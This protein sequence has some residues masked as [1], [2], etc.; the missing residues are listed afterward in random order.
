MM[1]VTALLAVLGILF[2][3]LFHIIYC[4]TPSWIVGF[5]SGFTFFCC[6]SCAGRFLDFF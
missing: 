6:F 5:D 2:T 1:M 3:A 4:D